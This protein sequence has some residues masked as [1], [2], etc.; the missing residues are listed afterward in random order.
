MLR[1]IRKSGKLEKWKGQKVSEFSFF[2]L[3]FFWVLLGEKEVSQICEG[4][5][6]G[7][8]N[9]LLSL[10]SFSK[11][12]KRNNFLNLH[13]QLVVWP[14]QLGYKSE[15]QAERDP[16]FSFPEP[17]SVL[18]EPGLATGSL[19]QGMVAVQRRLRYGLL[20]QQGRWDRTYDRNS[21]ACSQVELKWG[22]I[23]YQGAWARQEHP[24][25]ESTTPHT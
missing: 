23:C 7:G 12:L 3:F 13:N 25:Q 5:S 11:I 16:R 15:G 1:K 9:R 14:H 19:W 22:S 8:K 2:W 17:P 24:D 20:G 6:E 21:G 4:N 18:L 10:D